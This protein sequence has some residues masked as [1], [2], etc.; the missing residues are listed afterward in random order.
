MVSHDSGVLFRVSQAGGHLETEAAALHN[1]PQ[2]VQV[3]SM[4]GHGNECVDQV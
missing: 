2:Q 3:S 4:F 1:E